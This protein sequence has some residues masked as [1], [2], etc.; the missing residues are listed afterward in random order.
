MHGG[1]LPRWLRG[2]KTVRNLKCEDK[3]DPRLEDK[4]ARSTCIIDMSV[5]KGGK[6]NFLEAY[7]GRYRATGQKMRERGLGEAT[8]SSHYAT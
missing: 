3:M 7:L 8:H 4:E 5:G 2:K 6:R 1:T